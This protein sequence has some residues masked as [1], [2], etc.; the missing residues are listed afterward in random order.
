MI[1]KMDVLKILTL[2]TR[3]KVAHVASV[4]LRTTC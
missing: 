2:I 4:Y 1:K 3:H